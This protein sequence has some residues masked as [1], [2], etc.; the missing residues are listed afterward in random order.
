MS[1][2]TTLAVIGPTGAITLAV[3]GIGAGLVLLVR[4]LGGYRRANLISD[5][6]SAT[7]SAVAVGENRISGTIEAAELTLTS[8]L[9]S[10]PC[11]YYRSSVTD[12]NSRSS[13][14]IYHDERAVGFR[15]RDASGTLRVF[16]RGA[17]FDVP[18]VFDA[19]SGIMGDEPSGLRLREGPATATAEPDQAAQVAD[20]LTVHV[21]GS[22]LDGSDGSPALDGGGSPGGSLLGGRRHYHE[23]RLTVGDPVTIIGM[24]LPFDQLTDPDGSDVLD[25]ALDVGSSDPEVAADL[26]AARASGG[27]ASSPEQAWGNAAIPGFG[28]G[29]PVRSPTLDPAARP[30]PLA[31]PEAAGQA[32]RT[33]D[34]EPGSLVLACQPGQRLLVTAGSPAVAVQR[35]DDRFM[36]GLLGGA[37]AIASALALAWLASGGLG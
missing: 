6:A 15:V 7:I 1:S 22:A 5:I 9:Q 14:R 18:D 32:Q 33:F 19:R 29:Q 27:L 35:A 8:P 3:M 25:A 23:A 34:I 13:N 24:V 17:A 30:E 4:G 37:L 16:P 2:L 26:A 11:V 20:L 21:P 28:I 36:V 12:D 10:A 31:G